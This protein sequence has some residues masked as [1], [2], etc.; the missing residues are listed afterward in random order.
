LNRTIRVTYWSRRGIPVIRT[1]AVL[2]LLA[3]A[4]CDSRGIQTEDAHT[5][6]G[7]PSG[8]EDGDGISDEEEGREEAVDTDGDTIPDF[9]DDDSDNDTIPDAYESGDMDPETP[10]VD[11]D[12][13]GTPDFRDTDSDDNGILDIDEGPEDID[14]DG[15]PN[16][17]DPDNDGDGLE[18]SVELAWDP[19]IEVDFDSDGIPDYNDVDSDDD[20][21]HDRDEQDVDTDDDGWPDRLDRDADND[22]ILDEEEAGDSDI[23]TPPVDSDG[24]YIPDFRDLDSD[25]DGLSDEYESE[26]GTDPTCSDSDADGVSDYIE[27][28]AGTD[29]LDGTSNPRTEGHFFFIMYYNEPGTP[30]DEL[31]D[32]D[33]TMDHLVLTTG[34]TGPVEVTTVLRDDLTD[35]V[36]VVDAFVDFVEP[37]VIGGYP[38]PKDPSRIC[39]SGL[40]VAD[41]HEPLDGRPDSFTS[42]P[43]DTPVCFD[44]HVKAN[45]TIPSCEEPQTYPCDIDLVGDGGT[46]LDTRTLNFLIPAAWGPCP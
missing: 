7:V 14:G 19:P 22:G 15:V 45:T 3:L 13:D 10:A 4:G 21:I 40:E 32:P 20:T 27:V 25:N 30:E 38:D 18:D 34:S 1:A 31:M 44:I 8:D 43:P 39:V 5:D 26:I 46:I 42:V 2:L 12:G 24:D 28:G 6:H 36:D 23:S 17:A 11:S 29:P 9:Q 35:L 33:P 16:Y 37:S 41:L